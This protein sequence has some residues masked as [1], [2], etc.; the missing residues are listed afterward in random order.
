IL[1]QKFNF[2]HYASSSSSV[3]SLALST[4]SNLKNASLSYEQSS[5]YISV[6]F[7]DHDQIKRKRSSGSSWS[8]T[9][10]EQ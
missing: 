7:Q 1:Y 3:Y 4:D 9:H 5:H 6:F 10:L 2:T 8:L